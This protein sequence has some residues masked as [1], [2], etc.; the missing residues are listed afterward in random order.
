MFSPLLKNNVRIINPEM[1]KYIKEQTN[2]S[3]EKLRNQYSI[4]TYNKSP[5]LHNCCYILP[6]V[7]LLSFLAGYQFCIMIKK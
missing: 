6:F 5:D 2:K 7:S 4:T 3:F 1:S